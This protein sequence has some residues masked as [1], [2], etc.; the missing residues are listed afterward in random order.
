MIRRPPR[1]QLFPSTTLLQS[2]DDHGTLL[3]RLARRG[4]PL[5]AGVAR[6]QL[7]DLLTHAVQVGAEL[8]QDL[9]GDTLALTDRKSTR[10]NS[11]HSQISYP[12][13]CCKQTKRLSNY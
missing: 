1:R 4:L 11:S 9:R 7:D 3:W 10:L 2:V 12:V 8:L 5:A 6:Q 13:L